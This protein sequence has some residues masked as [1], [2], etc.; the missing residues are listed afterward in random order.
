LYFFVFPEK[1]WLANPSFSVEISQI[2]L[3]GETEEQSVVSEISSAAKQSEPQQH[4]KGRKVSS[5]KKVKSYS[6]QLR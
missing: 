5:H 1:S 4:H 3:P 2:P 6:K